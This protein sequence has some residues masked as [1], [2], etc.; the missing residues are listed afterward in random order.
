MGLD[1]FQAS[2][3]ADEAFKR[4]E[5]ILGW[6]L[7]EVCSPDGDER[8]SVT[9]YTQPALYVTCA[10]IADALQHKGFSPSITAGHSAGEFAALY[11]AGSLDFETGLIVI[12][13]RARLMHE[14]AGP[15]A[16]AAVLGLQPQEVQ[17][18]CVEFSGGIV[19]AANYNSP[20][21]T[22]ITGEEQAIDDITDDLKQRGARRVVKLPVS[23]A[24]HS[25][26]MKEAQIEFN[27]FMMGVEIKRPRIAW[28]SNNTAQPE[29]DPDEIKSLLIAQFCES[30][31]WV[32]SMAY[33]S[34]HA[35]S[36]IECGPGEV[37]C[38][39]AKQNASEWPCNPCGTPS[40]LES[41]IQS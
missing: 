19:Q 30:V 41:I 26:L 25:P 2:P 14:K 34:S 21:Q 1:W 4:A 38:G 7:R 12:A 39:L 5:S 23:G 22:V 20:K 33:I 15:G 27:Q 32:D 9:L 3:V 6:P 10:I 37:L 35:E 24:F 16:M 40:D 36:G 17:D 18:A 11:A 28:V 13:E 29:D 8:L 31:R